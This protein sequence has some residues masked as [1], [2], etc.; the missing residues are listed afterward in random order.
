MII[1]NAT[2]SAGSS[3]DARTTSGSVDDLS[4]SVHLH[5]F[6]VLTPFCTHKCSHF[7]C[8]LN[9]QF[10]SR[11][12]DLVMCLQSV[13]SCLSHSWCFCNMLFLFNPIHNA[14][15]IYCNV[16]CWMLI[17]LMRYRKN[18]KV[19]TEKRLLMISSVC[20][21]HK[22]LSSYIVFFGGL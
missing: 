17:P 5:L 20:Y 19:S 9:A 7:S 14:F 8:A 12:L 1:C 2:Y 3:I 4:N 6:L 11:L 18:T 16:S 22:P 15:V 10:D 13:A 21:C